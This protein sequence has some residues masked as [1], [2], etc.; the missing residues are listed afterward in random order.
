[1]PRTR[2][3]TRSTAFVATGAAQA[4]DFGVEQAVEGF[5]DGAAHHIAEMVLDSGLIDLD[6]IAHAGM[7]IFHG[8]PLVWVAWSL[9]NH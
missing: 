3:T 8:G 4:I 2:I 7:R 5:L 9:P 1:M 6:D